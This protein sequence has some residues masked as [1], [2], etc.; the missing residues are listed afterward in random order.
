MHEDPLTRACRMLA[1]S[2]SIIEAKNAE[3][4]RLTAEVERH[5][6]TEEEREAMFS[7]QR[8]IQRVLYA[9]KDNLGGEHR[10]MKRDVS[11]IAGYLARTAMREG[12]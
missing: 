11:L 8:S 7:G 10:D 9:D 4:A 3:I 5:R 1:E 12:E 2:Q 6:M